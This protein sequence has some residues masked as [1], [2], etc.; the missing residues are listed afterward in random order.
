MACQSIPTSVPY[1]MYE[2]PLS[3]D[4]IIQSVDAHPKQ[5]KKQKG[6][7][8]RLAWAWARPNQLD[9]RRDLVRTST[10]EGGCELYT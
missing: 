6:S 9:G 8:V 1:A 3:L 4:P 10:R 7:V 2:S 5:I